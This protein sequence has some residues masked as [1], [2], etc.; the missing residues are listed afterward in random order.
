MLLSRVYD[1]LAGYWSDSSPH[2]SS[3][4]TVDMPDGTPMSANSSFVGLI[5]PP[6]VIDSDMSFLR[7]GFPIFGKHPCFLF[8]TFLSSPAVSLSNPGCG[9]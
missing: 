4:P 9:V 8:S 5:V 3:S 6:L 7:F 1:S 2:R